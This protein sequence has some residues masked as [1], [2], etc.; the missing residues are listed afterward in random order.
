MHQNK[1][2]I[3]KYW[4]EHPILTSLVGIFLSFIVLGF[5][6][7]CF[8]DIWTHHGSTTRI[9]DVVGMPLDRGIELLEDAD[10]QAVV[11]DSVYT[12]DRAPGSIVDVFPEANSVVKGGREVYLTI[13]AYFPEPIIIE[14]LLIDT[15]AKQAEAY[16]KSKGL[17]VE[18]RYVPS[19]FPDVVVAAICNGRPISVGS[20]VTANDVIV[21]EIGEATKVPEPEI[22]PL[23]VMI[24]SSIE[25]DEGTVATQIEE[26]ENSS[27]F[28]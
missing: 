8:L 10:L 25:V 17:R 15:S 13:V 18:R 19:E 24:E 2:S 5:L 23:D 22:D 26:E 3:K 4:N 11:S 12:K 21:L 6:C 16:L 1:K 9:P 20:Q 27:L 28:D 7:L 14:M